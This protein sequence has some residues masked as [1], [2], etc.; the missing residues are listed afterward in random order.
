[1]AARRMRRAPAAPDQTP[2]AAA[3]RLR[4]R[5][6]YREAAGASPQATCLGKNIMESPSG[7]RALLNPGA[8][9]VDVRL[10]QRRLALRHAV[11]AAGGRSAGDLFVQEAVVRIAR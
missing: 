9:L 6:Q 11:A 10:R 5:G 7:V 2:G 4:L 3:R 1:M 8:D